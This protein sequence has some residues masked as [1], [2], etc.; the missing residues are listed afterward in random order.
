MDVYHAI[1][2]GINTFGGSVFSVFARQAKTA[3]IV[4]PDKTKFGIDVGPPA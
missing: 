2:I 4:L 1:V 3:E